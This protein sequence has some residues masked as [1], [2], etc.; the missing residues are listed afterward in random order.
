MPWPHLSAQGAMV[1]C[2]PSPCGLPPP[3]VEWTALG[4]SSNWERP[5][6]FGPAPPPP[7][8]PPPPSSGRGVPVAFYGNAKF[9]MNRG[10]LLPL[11]T[12]YNL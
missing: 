1:G 3:R 2:E 5:S 11:L 9:Q 7:P 6:A 12:P 10:A 8:P 4:W